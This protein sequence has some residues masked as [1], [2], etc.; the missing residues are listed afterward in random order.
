MVLDFFDQ[1]DAFD[2]A[3]VIVCNIF[4]LF[5]GPWNKAFPHIEMDRLFWGVGES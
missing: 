1:K 2:I 3:L 4:S 5:P